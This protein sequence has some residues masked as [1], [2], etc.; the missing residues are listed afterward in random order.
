MA[1]LCN[2]VSTNTNPNNLTIVIII[3]ITIVTVAVEAASSWN[4]VDGGKALAVVAVVVV[5]VIKLASNAYCLPISAC[6]ASTLT[7]VNADIIRIADDVRDELLLVECQPNHVFF[8]GESEAK[9]TCK[10]GNKWSASKLT[11][12]AKNYPTLVP[13]EQ[14][15]DSR[16]Y[17]AALI[18]FALMF[19]FLRILYFVLSG[20]FL[21]GKGEEGSEEKP[22][23]C[24]CLCPC[25]CPTFL[26]RMVGARKR[27]VEEE[28]GEEDDEGPDSA[29]EVEGEQAVDGTTETTLNENFAPE[30]LD[31]EKNVASESVAAGTTA[32]G[33]AP[34]SAKQSE[35]E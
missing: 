12:I 33:E 15:F 29:E 23:R 34:K 35:K 4:D 32:S 10:T 24:D 27:D 16:Y 13:P 9:I 31:D 14:L 22:K 21:R 11:C 1:Q 8:N 28:R 17:V 20:I 6:D 18:M 19:V 5:V 7:L 3:I 30:A 25:S 2:K 26:E